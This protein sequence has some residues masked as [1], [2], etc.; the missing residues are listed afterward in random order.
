MKDIKDLTPEECVQI[1]KIIEPNIDWKF[2][3][4][5]E[6]YKWDGFDVVGEQ[7]SYGIYKNI[8]QIDYRK[9]RQNNISIMYFEDGLHQYSITNEQFDKVSAYINSL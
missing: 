8:V 4:P 1:A 9:T 2:T 6:E 5:S 3:V 7:D